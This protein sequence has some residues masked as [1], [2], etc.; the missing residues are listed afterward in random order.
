MNSS[1]CWSILD[2]LISL[3]LITSTIYEIDSINVYYAVFLL[4]PSS[5]YLGFDT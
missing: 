1:T 3:L 2:V 5:K 4:T